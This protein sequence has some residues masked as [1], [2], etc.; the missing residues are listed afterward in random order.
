M[1]QLFFYHLSQ[2]VLLVMR[3]FTLHRPSW[4]L[5][6]SRWMNISCQV[7]RQVVNLRAHGWQT[8]RFKLRAH[9]TRLYQHFSH[10]LQKQL[11]FLEFC[12]LHNNTVV[13]IQMRQRVFIFSK[14]R[15]DS[16]DERTW[17]NNADVRTPLNFNTTLLH[18]LYQLNQIRSATLVC[19]H[20]QD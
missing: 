14:L 8:V 12:R 4:I 13:W 20:I 17:R 5:E 6:S 11:L 7:T 9:S 10:F 1:L 19:S 15:T 2:R 16:H 18:P 3:T